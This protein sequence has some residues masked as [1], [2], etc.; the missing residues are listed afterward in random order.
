MSAF[1]DGVT[2][3]LEHCCNCGMPFAMTADF[4]RR[5]C[6]DHERFYCPAGHPQHYT[7]PTEA[8]K[9]RAEIERKAEMLLAAELRAESAEKSRQ[10]AAL[11]HRKMRARV[12]NGVCP[13]CNRTFQNLMQHMKSEHP[14][15]TSVPTLQAL[16]N[17]F[18]M[19]QAAVA[20]EAGVSQAQVSMFERG[21]P[22]PTRVKE[23]LDWW[24]QQYQGRAKETAP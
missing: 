6:E 20:Q 8:Q 22:V 19:S 16:R 1:V 14:D 9:L 4:M 10:Q 13:C 12:A 2:F 3:N 17:A 11:A 23:R 24:Q 15:F 5:R 21:Q 7:G 18:A